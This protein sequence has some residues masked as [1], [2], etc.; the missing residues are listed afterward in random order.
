MD[1]EIERLTKLI[2][3]YMAGTLPGEGAQESLTLFEAM[4]YT[5]EAP[6]K[7]VRPVL[8]LLACKAVYGNEDEA[9]PY[10]CAIEFIHNYSLIHD[11]LPAMDNDDYRRG[12]LT[13]HKVF[14]EAM[15]I[16]AG[17]GLLSAAFELMYLDSVGY[18][19]DAEALSKRVLAGAAIAE[20]CGTGGMVA[21]QVADIEAEGMAA[22]AELLD[23]IHRKKTAALIKAAVKAGAYIGGASER[24]AAALADYGEYLGL[25]F[26]ITDD[27]LDLGSEEGKASY[28]AIHGEEASRAFAE[29]LT[30][31]A[32]AAVKGAEGTDA[33]YTNILAGMAQS[34]SVR[35]K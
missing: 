24:T 15:A 30:V 16:L 34:L 13:N 35:L 20:G 18:I 22:G 9:L 1:R 3:S 5:L 8:L 27:I 32:I 17:D 4:R 28:P 26:Q 7:R 10:A 11:D 2:E 23:Y 14:G 33:L 12:N 6:G 19:H 21:G 25:A 31:R 29:E